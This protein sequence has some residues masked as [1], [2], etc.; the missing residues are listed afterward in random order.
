MYQNFGSNLAKLSEIIKEQKLW[1]DLKISL[2]TLCENEHFL[3]ESKRTEC[4]QSSET[5]WETFAQ[6]DAE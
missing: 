5:G 1:N 6:S 2:D 4:H 3:C